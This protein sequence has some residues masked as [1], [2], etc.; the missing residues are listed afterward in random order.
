[1]GEV[2]QV[3]EKLSWHKKFIAPIPISKQTNSIDPVYIKYLEPILH[4]VSKS[5]T[6]GP[7]L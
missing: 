5:T 3:C 2:E 6:S 1:M 7:R 4:R